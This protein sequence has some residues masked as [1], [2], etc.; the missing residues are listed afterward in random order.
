MLTGNQSIFQ[1]FTDL[2]ASDRRL[3]GRQDDLQA[4]IAIFAT[5]Q[6]RFIVLNGIDKRVDHATI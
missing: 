1:I 5:I 3:D 6:W 2:P 4:L